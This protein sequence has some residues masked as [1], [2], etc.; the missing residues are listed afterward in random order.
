M[1]TEYNT[2]TPGEWVAETG[3]IHGDE[4]FRW[5]VMAVDADDPNKKWF[6]AEIQNGAPG[7]SCAT[8]ERNAR[9]I[10]ASKE[11]LSACQ[12][13]L[14]AWKNIPYPRMESDEESSLWSARNAIQSAI[15][16]ATG[17]EPQHA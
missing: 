3:G 14:L 2:L 4:E 13:M 1:A 8:E 9:L 5:C 11:L 12:T 10:A 7:D 15:A 17:E 6:V 16:K